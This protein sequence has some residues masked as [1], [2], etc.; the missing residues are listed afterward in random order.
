VGA[1]DA[2]TS[3]KAERRIEQMHGATFTAGASGGFSEELRH[4]CL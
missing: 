4:H 2:V 1:N 3:Q